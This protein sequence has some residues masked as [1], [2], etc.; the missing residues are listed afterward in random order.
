M[1]KKVS[2]GSTY[3]KSHLFLQEVG[4]PGPLLF[5]N[6]GKHFVSHG[7]VAP[8]DGCLVLQHRH[9]QRITDNVQLL[10]TQVQPV[11]FRDVAQQVHCPEK[12]KGFVYNTQSKNECTNNPSK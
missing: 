12:T 7:E 10:V 3:G 4:H 5:W 8:H 9:Q 2:S 1:R 11:I 6:G